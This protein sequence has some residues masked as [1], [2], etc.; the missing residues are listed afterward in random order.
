MVSL[1]VLQQTTKKLD[2]L[3]MVRATG[4]VAGGISGG[5]AGHVVMAGGIGAVAGGAS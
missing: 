3:L 4:A 5:F 1:M 2:S